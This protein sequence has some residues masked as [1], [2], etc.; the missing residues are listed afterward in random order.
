MARAMSTVRVLAVAACIAVSGAIIRASEADALG[1]RGDVRMTA[2][3]LDYRV[4][5]RESI[6]ESEVPGDAVV[7][8]LPDGTVVYCIPDGDC[9]SYRAAG[10]ESSTPMSQEVRV[11]A[12][13]RGGIAARAHVRTRL[14]TDGFWPR[15]SEP[16]LV[17]TAYSELDRA[18]YRVRVGRQEKGGGLGFYRFDG[19]SAS[20]EAVD[21]VHIE[22]FAGRSLGRAATTPGVGDLLEENDELAPDEPSLLW[23][24]QAGFAPWRGLS[25]S[26]LYQRE[27]RFDGSGLYS[28]RAALDARWSAR[29]SAA[30]LSLDW[31]FAIAEM[32][33]TRLR[34]AQGISRD[35]SLRLEGRRYQPTFDLWTIWT[36][37]SPVA[38]LE[39]RGAVSWAVWRGLLIEIEEAYRDYEDTSTESEAFPIEADGWRFVASAHWN[40][41][42]WSSTAAYQ[43]LQ[44]FGAFKSAVDASVRRR[45]GERAHLGAYG[46]GTLQFGEF[47]LGERVIWGGGLE[48]F[49]AAGRLGLEA[50][51]GIDRHRFENRPGFEPVTQ[52]RGTLAITLDFGKDP[53]EAAWR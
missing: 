33:E 20:L 43:R 8:V 16:F 11:S 14:G 5:R 41:A 35:V 40:S 38:F 30:D 51:G 37:F 53:G 21:R 27:E 10:T 4:L 18:R 34:F 25:G 15:S 49:A 29:R 36:A 52:W 26:A 28:E 39:E 9:Y 6:P 24:F 47:R 31:D 23:G 45:I 2:S 32:T 17:V 44:G 22:G 42:R 1:F 19:A 12:W 50:R 3:Y 48:G 46:S 7:R 13:A